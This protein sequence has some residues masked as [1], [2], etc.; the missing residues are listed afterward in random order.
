MT[1]SHARRQI[2]AMGGGSFSV[3]PEGSALDAY[4]LALFGVSGQGPALRRLEWKPVEET[5]PSR[6]PL[7]GIARIAPHHP[8]P[9]RDLLR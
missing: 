1:A 3:E 8:V 7:L 5:E 4:V 6:R 9:R 2:V